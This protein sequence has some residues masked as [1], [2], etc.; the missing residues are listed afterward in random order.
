MIERRRDQHDAIVQ[1]RCREPQ[2]PLDRHGERTIQRYKQ[3]HTHTNKQTIVNRTNEH[4]RAAQHAGRLRREQLRDRLPWRLV[5]HRLLL[6]E[7][8]RSEQEEQTAIGRA[9]RVFARLDFCIV[10]RQNFAI[11]SRS[12]GQCG[13]GFIATTV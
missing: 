10:L 3:T 7:L 6:G 13:H 9:S 12:S 8:V 5:H 2:Q 1:K 11:D 4:E